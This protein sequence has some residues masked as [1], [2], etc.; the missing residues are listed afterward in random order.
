[1]QNR[2]IVTIAAV[3]QDGT[4]TVVFES[5]AE[6]RLSSSGKPMLHAQGRVQLGGWPFQVGV[7]VTAVQPTIKAADG[8]TRIPDPNQ[9]TPSFEALR[10]KL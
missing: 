1:M 5:G 6:Y 2:Y 10:S 3:A 4:K 8:T 7:N 9:P